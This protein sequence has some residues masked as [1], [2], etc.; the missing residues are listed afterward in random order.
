MQFTKS[1][2]MEKSFVG[3]AN[4][5]EANVWAERR[6]SGPLVLPSNFCTE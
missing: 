3:P 6:L 5:E 1:M 2:N 4:T